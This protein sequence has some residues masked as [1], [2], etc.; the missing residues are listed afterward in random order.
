MVCAPK[1]ALV[2][3]AKILQEFAEIMIAMGISK[4]EVEERARDKSGRN[5]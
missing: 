1:D 4:M 5:C 2:E 3:S